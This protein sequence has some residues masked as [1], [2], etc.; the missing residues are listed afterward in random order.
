MNIH[1][2]DYI[3]IRVKINDLVQDLSKDI[4]EERE[5]NR[6]IKLARES[7]NTINNQISYHFETIRILN[8]QKE[9]TER[10]LEQLFLQIEKSYRE[11]RKDENY[12][13]SKTLVRHM[14]FQRDGNKCKNCNTTSNLT[15]DH[16]I[17]VKHGGTSEDTN[18]QTLC[19]KC[20]S[21]KGA[22]I[23]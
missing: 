16:I 22:K 11:R 8:T 12:K 10:A 4:Y 17:P 23:L 14:I 21:S 5:I 15:I 7:Q 2:V 20:N 1:K 19:R 18:L 9:K 6:T 3:N 13:I